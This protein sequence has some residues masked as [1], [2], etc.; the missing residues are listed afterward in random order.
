MKSLVAILAAAAALAPLSAANAQP[1]SDAEYLK[2]ARCQALMHSPLF[3]KAEV[4]AIDAAMSEEGRDARVVQKAQAIRAKITAD[5]QDLD[6]REYLKRE[7][8]T[9][10]KSWHAYA[11]PTSAVAAR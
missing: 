6:K 8:N 10:C 7:R 5:L 1:L 2:A 9:R 4:R 11:E 3:G